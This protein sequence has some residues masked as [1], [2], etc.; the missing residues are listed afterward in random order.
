MMLDENNRNFKKKYVMMV[1]GGKMERAK[2]AA[3]LRNWTRFHKELSDVK[4]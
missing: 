4:Q 3:D 1:S 2:R